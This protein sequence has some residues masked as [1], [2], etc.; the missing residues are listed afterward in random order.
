MTEQKQKMIKKMLITAFAVFISLNFISALSV[1]ANYI[2]VSPGEEG[3]VSIE[4]ENNDEFDAEFV[5][6]VNAETELDFSVETKN[7]IIGQKGKITLRIVNK[8]LGE[9]KFVSVQVFP[10]GYDLLSSDV[11]Y[12]GNIPSDDSDSAGFD[13]FF[14]T[15]SPSVY[16]KV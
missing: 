16:A 1:N 8:G 13:V 7:N 6:K 9:V 3:K 14:N 15:L 11:V 4:I 12:I 2:S 5:L 10:Q